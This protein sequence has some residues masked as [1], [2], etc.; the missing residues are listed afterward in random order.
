[1]QPA[2][3]QDAQF[4]IKQMRF[5]VFDPPFRQMAMSACQLQY[6]SDVFVDCMQL[7]CQQLDIS[8]LRAVAL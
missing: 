2:T 4:Y 6:S 7:V 1:M 5:I 8:D 3:A